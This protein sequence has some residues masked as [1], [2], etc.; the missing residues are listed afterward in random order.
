MPV[1]AVVGAVAAV[2]TVPGIIA[3]GSLTVLGA[4]T[5]VGAVLGAIGAV[6]KNKTL[7]LIGAGI[8][9]VGG[10]GSLAFGSDALGTVDELFGASTNAGASG[11]AVATS[12]V[13]AAAG[14]GEAVGGMGADAGIGTGVTGA[15]AGTDITTSTGMINS[16]AINPV[17]AQAAS[18]APATGDAAGIVTGGNTSSALGQSLT[19]PQTAGL[20]STGVSATMPTD[21]AGITNAQLSTGSTL[22]KTGG[23][24]NWAK[25][26]QLLAYG[27][28]QSGGAFISGLTDELSPAQVKAL[29]AQANANNAAAGIGQRQL[30]NMKGNIPKATV[31]G[32]VNPSGGLINNNTVKTPLITGAP[33]MGA[34]A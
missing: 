13:D 5:A 23:F 26:N 21:L 29:E 14:A 34:A 3:A 1:V 18:M 32:T 25:N 12:A 27:V 6:T 8:G 20:T 15:Q 17:Q 22:A 31:T 24:W 30:E 9:L 2:A 28:L 10:I 11:S 16:A 19:A 7:G 4:M 33:N